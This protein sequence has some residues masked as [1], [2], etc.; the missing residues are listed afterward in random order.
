[1]K[2]IHRITHRNATSPALSAIVLLA[3]LAFATP[4]PAMNFSVDAAHSKVQFKVKHMAVSTVTGRFN[5]ADATFEFDPENKVLES[6][7]ATIDPSSIDTGN[8]R[9]D[10]HLRSADFF[11]VENYPLITFV[12]TDI[13]AIDENGALTIIGDLTMRGVTKEITLQA[14]YGGHLK[15]PWGNDRVGF[16]ATGEVDR[17]DYG[18]SWD[19]VIESGGL[20]VSHEV[21]IHLEIEGIHR[22]PVNTD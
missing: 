6:V 22:A 15:D 3:G 21:E 11:D 5:K 13:S 12:S 9:R 1:M 17:M 8:E 10:N 16:I 19:N 14:E 2:P 7:S 20:V 18:V 4:A